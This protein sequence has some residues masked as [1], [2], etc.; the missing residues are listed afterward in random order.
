[1]TTTENKA[2]QPFKPTTEMIAAAEAVFVAVAFEQTVRP[3]VEGYKR[4]ILAERDW[5]MSPDTQVGMRRTGDKPID[6]RITDIK[7]AWLMSDAD[8]AEYARLCNAAR[9]AANLVVE[10]DA[11]CPLGVAEEVTRQAKRKL[12][13]VMAGVSGIAPET[14]STM[15]MEHYEHFVD[16][17]LRLLA[18]FVASAV[19]ASK[20]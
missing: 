9:I 3:I 13:E 8:F 15:R 4:K 18:P 12:A 16:L 10:S 1:M 17:A 6:T 7:Y 11:H 5:H 14:I 19:G 20:F 2:P